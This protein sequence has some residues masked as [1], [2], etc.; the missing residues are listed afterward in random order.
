MLGFLS[1]IEGFLLPTSTVLWKSLSVG[2]FFTGNIYLQYFALGY[3]FELYVNILCGTLHR[4]VVGGVVPLCLNCSAPCF[5]VQLY[6]SFFS[7]VCTHI[8]SYGRDVLPKRKT[9][10]CIFCFG[11][12]IFFAL[13]LETCSTH[14][15]LA[16]VILGLCTGCFKVLFYRAV[17]EEFVYKYTG[18]KVDQMIIFFKHE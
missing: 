14:G 12:M 6:V 8:W 13:T 7:F 1:V 18:Q 9:C 5:E 3:Y 15:A 17:I 10:M 2:A 11:V 16:A 4:V